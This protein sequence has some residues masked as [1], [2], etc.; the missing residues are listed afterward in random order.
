MTQYSISIYS[1]LGRVG[2]KRL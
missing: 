2:L 1:W